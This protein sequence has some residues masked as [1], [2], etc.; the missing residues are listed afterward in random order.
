MKRAPH[1]AANRALLVPAIV[2]LNCALT[3][4][5]ASLPFTY[6]K[7]GIPDLDQERQVA[8]GHFGLPNDGL[9]YCVPTSSMDCLAYIANHGY[10]WM[11]PN[12]YR[13]WQDQYFYDSA[14]IE[15]FKMGYFFMSTDED[16]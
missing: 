16:A 8:D 15:I 4:S 14:G 9:E 5:A 2:A 10:G 1:L 3:A 7:G 11:E 12:G 6:R 13:N